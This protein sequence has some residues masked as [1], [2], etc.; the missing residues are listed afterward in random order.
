MSFCFWLYHFSYFQGCILLFFSRI[1][2]EAT[3]IVFYAISAHNHM[4]A[5]G[6]LA[7]RVLDVYDFLSCDIFRQNCAREAYLIRQL[8]S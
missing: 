1:F 4:Q 5:C 6:H 8:K 3:R 2:H 7:G